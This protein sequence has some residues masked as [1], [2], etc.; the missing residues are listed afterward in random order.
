MDEQ[1]QLAFNILLTI[2][3]LVVSV[4]FLF[5]WRRRRDLVWWLV[6]LIFF[7][8]GY[9][10]LIFNYYQDIYEDIG[11]GILL[12]AL[13]IVI[14]TTF[15]E[16]IEIMIKTPSDKIKVKNEKIFL[17]LTLIFSFILGIIAIVLFTIYLSSELVI[18][19]SILMLMLFIPLTAFNFRIYR[20]KRSIT[21]LF[22]FFVFFSGVITSLS[23]LL[24]NFFTWGEAMNTAMDFVFITLVLTS[25][26]AAPIEQRLTNSEEKYRTLS[27]HLE[28][29]VDER[30][31]QLTL[32]KQE[33]ETISYSVSHDL[34]APLRSIA[35]FAKSLYEQIYPNLDEKNKDNLE[36]IINSTDRMN[37]L[38]KDLLTLGELSQQT[39]QIETVN[40][41]DIANEILKTLVLLHPEIKIECEIQ[42][43]IFAECDPKLIRT[44][45]ENL[46]GNAIKFSIIKPQP[47]ISFG[48]M[49]E[50]EREIFY[51]KDNGIGFDM[52]YAH[53][54]F[55][56]FQRLHS[57]DDFEGTG[58][59]LITVK[60]IIDMHKG[61]VWAEAE[62]NKGATFYFTLVECV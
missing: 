20:I 17:T 44:L 34:R 58:I 26:V 45:L 36:R 19:I 55:G 29:L 40:L 2:Y 10:V 50:N 30:T 43:N 24:S 33:I 7:T 9:F 5:A 32:A 42:E 25:G 46:L 16:Y 22:M 38:I 15:L 21:R 62:V 61:E 35:G 18:I 23:I 1:Y 57:T 28:E 12:V 60:R 41:S 11:N 37:E 13:L 3:A 47:L 51:V 53:K 27:E 52:D 59:G 8:A 48:K 54:L 6:A 56:L 31:K 49:N 14:I 4:I 39:C